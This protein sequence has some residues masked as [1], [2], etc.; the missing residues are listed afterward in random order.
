MFKVNVKVLLKDDVLDPQGKTVQN[1]LDHLGYS[2][3][4]NVRIGK[5]IEFLSDE[6]DENTLRKQVKEMC[7]SVLTNPV[8]EKYE[9]SMEPVVS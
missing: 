1:A 7:N 8:V 6:A 4:R 2:G 3:I 5:S 9:F